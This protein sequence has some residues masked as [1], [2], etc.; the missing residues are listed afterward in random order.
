METRVEI[1]IEKVAVIFLVSEEASFIIGL[2]TPKLEPAKKP[3][4]D[5]VDDLAIHH[6]NIFN[7]RVR[8]TVVVVVLLLLLLWILTLVP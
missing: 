4:K 2:K 5:Q 8:D 3:Q 7:E 1:I 6:T